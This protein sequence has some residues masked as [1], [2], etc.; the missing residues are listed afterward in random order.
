[1]LTGYAH[2]CDSRVRT[3]VPRRSLAD[4][5]AGAGCTS[6]WTEITGRAGR[7]APHRTGVR[8]CRRCCWSAGALIAVGRLSRW[9]APWLLVPFALSRW[10][11]G[12]EG[13][14]RAAAAL[15]SAGARLV[16]AEL[17]VAM[18]PDR[19][20]HR[21]RSAPAPGG[22]SHAAARGAGRSAP[23]RRPSSCSPGGIAVAARHGGRG[24][25]RQPAGGSRP[26]DS[27][28]GAR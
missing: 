14:S 25:W 13:F 12:Q 16:S 24:F 9:R 17:A 5:A 6:P 22:G 11:L 20:L 1:M 23:P 10:W 27:G 7:S 15:T 4:P 21:A 2:V 3:T 19:L 26:P 8:R 18:R 28:R